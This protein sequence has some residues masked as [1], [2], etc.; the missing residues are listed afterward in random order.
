MIAK[1]Q[2]KRPAAQI[3]SA[4]LFV[5]CAINGTPARAERTVVF[6]K[7]TQ[8]VGTAMTH[9]VDSESPLKMIGPSKGS[10]TIKD[11]Q[12]L[13]LIATPEGMR[14]FDT[15]SA[16][17]PG[18]IQH[19]RVHD[20]PITENNL[21]TIA[22]MSGLTSLDLSFTDLND[23]TFK[24]IAGMKNLKRLDL[25]STL[26]RGLTLNQL[27]G[28]KNLT[29]LDLAN[30]R[31]H[32]FAIN[33]IVESCPNLE[34]LNLAG[35][36]ITDQAILKIQN[37]KHLQKLKIAGTN[38]SDKYIDKLMTLKDLQKLSMSNTRVSPEKLIELRKAKP[39]CKF[40]FGKKDD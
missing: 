30:T 6:P 10:V 26:I 29:G 16:L 36:R 27:K 32:D 20:V 13:Y 28:L 17:K 8:P 23:S 24:Y 7:S 1:I 39:G 14:Y 15:L 34:R 25:S 5:L 21:K 38:I 12:A 40:V 22:K 9:P 11:G 35:T 19:L 3:I 31:T 2:S 4:L 33:T 37:L 18:D